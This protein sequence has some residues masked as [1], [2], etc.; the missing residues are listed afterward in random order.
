MVRLKRQFGKVYFV[1]SG[2]GDPDL[3]TIRAMNLLK[4][5]DVIVYD[6]LVTGSVI[7]LIPEVT[8]KIPVRQR[9]RDRGMSIDEI[10][11]V[12]VSYALR[13]NSVVRLKSGDPL[14]FGR[15]WEEI[16]FL[17]SAGIEYEI[18]PGISSALASAALAKIPLTDRRFSSS[19]AVVTGHE[20]KDKVRG[21]VD[22]RKLSAAVDTL[23]V[24]MGATNASDYT[25]EMIRAGI[26]GSIPLTAVCNVS[27]PDQRIVETTL[28]DVAEG[29]NPSLGNLCVIMI[30]I[31]RKRELEKSSKPEVGIM[32]DQEG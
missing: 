24:L 30:S 17:V 3:L 27:R 8:V 10:G 2:P 28:S 20:A 16:A 23:I 7:D 9:P 26:D 11:A 22:W 13:G 1:G 6:A 32:L 18:V 21:R 19:F 31:G 12:L 4:K 29:R 15:L 14:I 25:R 5:S